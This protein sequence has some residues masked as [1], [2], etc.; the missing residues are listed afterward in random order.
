MLDRE[1][2]WDIGRCYI[3]LLLTSVFILRN[4][5]DVATPMLLLSLSDQ[6]L[7]LKFYE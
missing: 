1:A 5:P 4:D 6:L 3:F 7:S 2:R